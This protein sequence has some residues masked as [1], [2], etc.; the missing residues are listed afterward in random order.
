MNKVLLTAFLVAIVSMCGVS[1]AQ[2]IDLTAVPD[3]IV[4]DGSYTTEITAQLLDNSGI[5]QKQ[6][7]VSINFNTDNA[8]IVPTTATTVNTDA[9]GRAKITYKSAGLFDGQTLVTATASSYTQGQKTITEQKRVYV[10][11]NR[12]LGNLKVYVSPEYYA[13][14]GQLTGKVCVQQFN[15]DGVILK[16]PYYVAGITSYDKHFVPKK[17]LYSYGFIMNGQQIFASYVQATSNSNGIA[18]ADFKVSADNGW[19]GTVMV[20]GSMSKF[21][22]NSANAY[23][24]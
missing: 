3:I 17:P 23:F 4:A 8:K 18:C 6:S 5:V 11:L 19:T 15:I 14:D 16:R 2:S 10:P 21:T 9:F 13:A 24:G 1:F 22:P 20:M 7:G 12:F